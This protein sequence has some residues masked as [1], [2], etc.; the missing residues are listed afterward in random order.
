MPTERRNG[1]LKALRALYNENDHAK[2]ILDDF[3][4]RTNR[5]STTG[6]EQIMSRLRGAELP[7]WAVLK[8]FRGLGD[9]GYGRFVV[10]RRGGESRF[11]WTANPIEVGKAAQGEDLAI[12]SLPEL[13]PSPEIEMIT[14]QFKLRPEMT[15]TVQLPGDLTEKEAERFSQFLRSLPFAA[16]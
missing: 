15:V 3:A 14:H 2:V 12:T 8:L 11:V 1:E 5:Q 6:V 10:G 7:K 9:L 16:D 13:E 4:G